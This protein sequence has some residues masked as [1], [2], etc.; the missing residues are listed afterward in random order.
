MGKRNDPAVLRLHF[1][2]EKWD[3]AKLRALAEDLRVL[4][5]GIPLLEAVQPGQSIDV[6]VSD[7]KAKALARA[8]DGLIHAVWKIESLDKQI[9]WA[10][11]R[12]KMNRKKAGK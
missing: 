10:F 9:R 1:P 8:F 4:D 12:S 2:K 5:A 7:V 3:V 11:I 6:T